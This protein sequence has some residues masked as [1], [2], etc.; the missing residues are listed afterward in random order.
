ML[1]EYAGLRPCAHSED[2]R[3]FGLAEPRSQQALQPW[4]GHSRTQQHLGRRAAA[5]VEIEEGLLAVDQR[6]LL[7]P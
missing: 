7:D 2:V 3:N 1:K 5:L 4:L 6:T